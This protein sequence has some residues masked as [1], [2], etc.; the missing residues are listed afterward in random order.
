MYC[1]PS[2]KI[3]NLIL[4][5]TNEAPTV[6]PRSKKKAPS[7]TDKKG[8]GSKKGGGGGKS[9]GKK[10][11][12]NAGKK[13]D[14]NGNDVVVEDITDEM[15]FVERSKTMPEKQRDKTSLSMKDAEKVKVDVY[16][17]DDK[18]NLQLKDTVIVK[19][20]NG[21][22]QLIKAKT[23]IGLVR[24]VSSTSLKTKKPETKKG[25]KSGE[26][27]KGG[28]KSSGKDKKKKKK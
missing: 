19:E 7:K 16:I 10:G 6:T 15:P 23:D 9:G 11:G 25:K 12:K 28:A 21:E 27:S 3:F 14:V 13:P 20:K 2:L 22:P 5:E 24:P 26:K 4:E 1:I 17:P 8:K 18:A